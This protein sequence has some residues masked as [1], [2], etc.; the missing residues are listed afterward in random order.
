M[1]CI[2]IEGD[3]I[4]RKGAL[5]GGF[6]DIRKSRLALMSTI[7]STTKSLADAEEKLEKIKADVAA[8]ETLITRYDHILVICSDKQIGG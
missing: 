2:T 4:N 8:T 3:Q 6:H 5:S 1:D 7:R